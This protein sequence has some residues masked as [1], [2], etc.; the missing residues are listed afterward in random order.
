MSPYYS[1]VNR[2]AGFGCRGLASG[3]PKFAEGG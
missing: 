1:L 3:I 2:S